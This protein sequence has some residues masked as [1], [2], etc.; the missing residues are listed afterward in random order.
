MNSAK[1]AAKGAVIHRYNRDH[2]VIPSSAGGRRAADHAQSAG[3]VFIRS[4]CKEKM[5]KGSDGPTG[6]QTGICGK[7][8]QP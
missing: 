3:D 2:T 5:L 4:V 1:Q 8:H 7:V 6:A